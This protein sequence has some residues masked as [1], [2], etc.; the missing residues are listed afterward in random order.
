MG[1]LRML[2]GSM[3]HEPE[4]PPAR[5]PTAR[6]DWREHYGPERKR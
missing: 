2:A 6:G 3:P 5:M 4:P 1:A